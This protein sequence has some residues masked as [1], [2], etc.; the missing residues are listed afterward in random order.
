M[1]SYSLTRRLTCSGYTQSGPLFHTKTRALEKLLTKTLQPLSIVPVLAYPTGPNRLLAA[2]IP[3]YQPP[4]GVSPE[5]DYQPFAWAW[6]RRDAASGVYRFWDKGM[7]AVAQAIREVPGGIDGVCGF[8]QGGCVSLA[9]AA[10]METE[11]EMPNGEAADWARALREANGGRPLKFAVTYSGFWG[12]VDML[13][14][15]YEPKIKTPSLHYIGS[16]DTVV[17]ESRT[18]GLVERCE[19][20]TV[21]V[22]PGAHHVPIARE[23]A[24]PLAGFIKEHAKANS[25]KPGL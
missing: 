6:F 9:V 23:W 12:P 25:V 7:A 11:R 14:W 18:Q 10:A 5:D 4:E 1:G 22:H 8:S 16:L 21:I 15:C 20:P 3:G 2:D 13:K 19:N 24:M 17:E